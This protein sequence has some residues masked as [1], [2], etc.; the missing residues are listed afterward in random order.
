LKTLLVVSLALISSALFAGA[1][2]AAAPANDNRLSAH[3]V[4]LPQNLDGTTEE[5]TLEDG[6]NSGCE[7]ATKGSV[8][9]RVTGTGGRVAVGID[10]AGDLDAV[11]DAFNY[12]RSQP[13]NLDCAATDKRGIGV[14]SFDTKKGVPYFVRV[15]QRANSVAGTFSL[16]FLAASGGARKPGKHLK[17]GVAHDTVNLAANPSD[18]WSITMHAGVSY[19][20][21]LS[22]TGGDGCVTAEL[23]GPGESIG[24]GRSIASC[25]HGQVLFTPGA[26]EGGRYAIVVSS[27]SHTLETQRYRLAASR[28]GRDDHA[29]GRTWGRRAIHGS[30][31]GDGRDFQDIYNFVLTRR[32]YVSLRVHSGADF[33]VS[34]YSA[35]GHRLDSSSNGPIDRKLQPG[36]YFA[37]VYAGAGAKGRYSLRRTERAI[38]HTTITFGGGNHFLADVGQS[39]TISANVLPSSRGRLLITLERKDP[40]TGWVFVRRYRGTGSGRSVSYRP[41]GVG[42]YRARAEFKGSRNANPSRSGWA[43]LSVRR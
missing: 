22:Q 37:K 15:A 14:I 23:A 4:S 42:E 9:Y 18:A 11:I 41:P 30:L 8:W 10:A 33:D 20:I 35:G 26:D 17:H 24:E 19:A 1:A 27:D 7:S 39:V 21:N 34:L 29:P 28:A 13:S 2:S 25:N 36:N 6:E 3:G 40:G 16:R 32:A 5:A 43:H 31:N 38:T 12:S